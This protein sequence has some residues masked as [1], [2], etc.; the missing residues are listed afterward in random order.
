MSLLKVCLLVVRGF[1]FL[2]EVRKK[3]EMASRSSSVGMKVINII[4]GGKWSFYF[5]AAFINILR[6]F[7]RFRSIQK[8][9][10]S[11]EFNFGLYSVGFDLPLISL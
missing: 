4:R 6:M 9:I 11:R 1:R 5:A 8:Y 2:I 7:R 3:L 10:I